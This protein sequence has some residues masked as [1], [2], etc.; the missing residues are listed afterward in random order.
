MDNRRV[1]N[2]MASKYLEDEISFG[3]ER[4]DAGYARKG[5]TLKSF[6]LKILRLTSSYVF[7]DPYHYPLMSVKAFSG[8]NNACL[9]SSTA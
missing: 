3:R 8:A 7:L 5:C 9:T 2:R 4:R 6:R 1:V